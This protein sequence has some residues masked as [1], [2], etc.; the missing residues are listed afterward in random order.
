MCHVCCHFV[1]DKE[2]V[3]NV[4]THSYVVS[5]LGYQ[6]TGKVAY[7]FAVILFVGFGHYVAFD[8]KHVGVL[9]YT[10]LVLKGCPTSS[11]RC[12]AKFE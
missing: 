11:A 6:K 2:L 10:S 1:T 3:L 8:N 5:F 9:H 12:A 4:F 7:K